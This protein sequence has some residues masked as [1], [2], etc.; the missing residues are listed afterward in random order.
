MLYDDTVPGTSTTFRPIA[1]SKPYRAPATTYNSSTSAY[2]TSTCEAIRSHS[3]TVDSSY[4]SSSVYMTFSGV[5][6]LTRQTTTTS[7]YLYVASS[8]HPTRLQRA[9]RKGHGRR[10]NYVARDAVVSRSLRWLYQHRQADSQTRGNMNHGHASCSVY[11]PDRVTPASCLTS[12][13]GERRLEAAQTVDLYWQKNLA[14]R[15]P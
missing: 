15:N 11:R 3:L 8:R 6:L 9:T 12:S 1:C 2:N 4:C 10:R 14:T 5:Y 7:T 13:S